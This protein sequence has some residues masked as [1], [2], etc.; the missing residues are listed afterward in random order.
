MNIVK[1]P[2]TSLSIKN[3]PKE[4]ELTEKEIAILL[5]KGYE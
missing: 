1:F 5:G 4:V 2:N 3:P